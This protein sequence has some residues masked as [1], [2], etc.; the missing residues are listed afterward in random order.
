ME[1]RHKEI[2]VPSW[3]LFQIAEAAVSQGKTSE[4]DG[5]SEVVFKANDLQ[6]RWPVSPDLCR[7]TVTA[8]SGRQ[9]EKVSWTLS[10]VCK[11]RGHCQNGMQ[12]VEMARH[13]AKLEFNKNV[14]L[15]KQEP[16]CL[17]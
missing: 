2:M 9:L 16:P 1:N 8:D 5:T 10:E 15:H 14:R 3:P 13:M 7:W 17:Q 12:Y 11:V 4:G 6:F